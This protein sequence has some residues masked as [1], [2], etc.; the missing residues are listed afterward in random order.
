ML[1]HGD[2]DYENIID[3]IETIDEEDY[4]KGIYPKVD[5]QV[6]KFNGD[7]STVAF[8]IT[9]SSGTTIN[10]IADILVDGEMVHNYDFDSTILIEIFLKD[11]LVCLQH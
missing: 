11:C 10:H 7:G 3:E 1:G 8:T 5:E 9:V 4:I 2:E 6:A